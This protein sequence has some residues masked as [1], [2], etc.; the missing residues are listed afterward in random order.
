MKATLI[1]RFK[2]VTP[3]GGVIELVVWRVPKPV[4]PSEHGFKYR[5]AYAID[6]VRVVGF[7]N[8][9]GKGDH[10][11]VRG[12]ERRY[13]FASVEQLIEDFIAAVDAARSKT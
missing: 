13:T 11:H 10:C 12:A 7:D 4:S 8:E 9:R 5:A 3:D 2:D 1:T 6:G